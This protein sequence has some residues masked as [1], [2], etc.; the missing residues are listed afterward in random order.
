MTIASSMSP[1]YL[2]VNP[3]FYENASK[4]R[5]QRK[6]SEEENADKKSDD[7]AVEYD[8]VS[9]RKS[10]IKD[11]DI[12]DLNKTEE[13][14]K[15]KSEQ[16]KGVYSGAN[17]RETEENQKDKA[18]ISELEK[19]ER[20]VLAHEAAHISAGGGFAGT[21]KYTRQI[22]PDGK[23]YITG[24]EVTITVPP[25]SDP[26]EIIRNMQQVKGAALAPINPSPQ[27][28]NVAAAA[29][30]AQMQAESELAA[31]D[32]EWGIEAQP[33]RSNSE[34]TDRVPH[35][36][37]MV[38]EYKTSAHV[39]KSADISEN[40]VKETTFSSIKGDS[41]IITASE[42]YGSKLA[43]LDNLYNVRQAIKIYYMTSS[44]Y[45]LWTSNNGY[46]KTSSSPALA[47]AQFLN[48]AA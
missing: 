10:A 39:E 33:V 41:V 37:P 27:D 4:L 32:A 6:I 17:L 2:Q 12:L 26:E 1:G 11:E 36:T 22:G 13:A 45:G 3:Y 9:N 8:V 28:I 25:S 19:T 47:Q 23:S 46:E 7:D 29:A 18:I 38:K 34:A 24:G 35:E 20:E 31:H 5:E 15:D 30:N 43:P 40:Q 21:P 14:G 44:P 42:Q 16:D 48:M